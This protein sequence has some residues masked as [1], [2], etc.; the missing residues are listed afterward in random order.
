MGNYDSNYA[1]AQEI[2]ARL[3]NEPIPF[4]SVYSICL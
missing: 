1:I 3:G 2:S 4:D